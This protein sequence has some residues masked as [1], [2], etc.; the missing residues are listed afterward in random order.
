M[1]R[2]NIPK[3]D[4]RVPAEGP[5]QEAYDLWAPEARLLMMF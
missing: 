1:F 5:D 3:D 4:K 2:K